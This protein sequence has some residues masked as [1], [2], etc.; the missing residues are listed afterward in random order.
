[1][2]FF[3]GAQV[4]TVV[5]L[6]LLGPLALAESTA[7]LGQL[8][9]RDIDAGQ[10][11]RAE[12][13]LQSALKADPQN[14]SLW[15]LLGVTR[16]QLKKTDPAIEAFEKALPLA[17]EKAP[18]YFDLGLLYMEKN[19]LAKAKEAYDHGLALDPSNVPANQ[20]Y[21]YLL[22]QQ[23]AFQEATV[24]LKRLEAMTPGDIPSR[25]SLVEAYFKAGMKD[26]GEGEVDELLKSHLFTLPQ[27]LALAKLLL[28]NG[29][30][31]SARQVLESLTSSWPASAE[32]HGELGVLLN[33]A[34]K[35]KEAATELWQAL[36]LEPNSERY[37]LEYGEALIDSQQYLVALQFL[38]GV[39]SKFADQPYFGYQLALTDICLQRFPEA[40]SVLESLA[41]EGADSGKVQFL[42]GGAYELSGELQKGEEHYRNAIQ[43]APQEPAYYR[44]LASLLQK[45]GPEHLAESIELLSK[46]LALDPTDVQ[47]KIILARCLEK[48]GQLDEA[49]SLLEQAVATDPASRRAHSALA[50][51][52]RR[53]RKLAQAE[54]E[55]SIAAKL[56]DQKITKDWDIWGP[57]SAGG[58]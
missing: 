56:E 36:K 8:A 4:N 57:K 44:V 48:Q 23:G 7:T 41:R 53:Q 3:K 24:P 35:S 31:D 54:Q 14:G 15:F 19:D 50:E 38:Q 55:Q 11:S 30:T 20:N 13:E 43:L 49:A 17:P 9:E 34:D 51:L 5:V 42:L 1:M 12:A 22:I 37:S 39:Q 33:Q 46:A 25:A 45:Q 2:R 40:I 29:E 32:A 26:Q 28:A 6:C 52:Y 47:S 58:P 18:V 27:G 16:A 10:Y 21:A